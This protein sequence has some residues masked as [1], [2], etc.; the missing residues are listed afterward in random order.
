MCIQSDIHLYLAIENNQSV[1]EFGGIFGIIVQHQG[2]TSVGM[3][4][5]VWVV[6]KY[7]QGIEQFNHAVVLFGTQVKGVSIEGIHGEK[8]VAQAVYFGFYGQAK[9]RYEARCGFGGLKFH[10]VV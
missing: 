3:R 4:I 10:A 6:D 8:E 9:E 5:E 1:F 2:K 7:I